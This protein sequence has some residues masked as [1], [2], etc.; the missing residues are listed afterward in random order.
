M[1]GKFVYLQ[2]LAFPFNLT[3]LVAK[4]KWRGESAGKH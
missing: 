3:C 1:G 4:V 2:S